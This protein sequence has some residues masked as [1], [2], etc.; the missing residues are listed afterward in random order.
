MAAGVRWADYMKPTIFST[1]SLKQQKLKSTSITQLWIAL[2]NF[3]I[4]IGP[5]IIQF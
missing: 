5:I 3:F 1:T 2:H 4:Q